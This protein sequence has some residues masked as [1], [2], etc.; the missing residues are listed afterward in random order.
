MSQPELKLISFTLCPYVQRARITLLKKG[1]QHEIEYIDLDSP[2]DWFFDI[3]PLEKVP[4]LL[5]DTKP[6][7]ESMV[8]C[9]YLDEISPGSLYPQDPFLRAQQRAWIQFGDTLLNNVYGTMTAEDEAGFKR[10]KAGVID[11]LDILEEQISE[12]DV[13]SNEFGMLDVSIAPTFRYMDAIRLHAGVDFYQ[14]APEVNAWAQRLAGLDVV[15]QA[16]PED[17]PQLIAAY[18]RRPQTV[19]KSLID[20]HTAN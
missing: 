5:V 14:A 1:L 9:E 17:Y 12:N 2:P 6:L 8:I 13:F 3:S 11:K 18:L 10:N 15:K 7:F 19:M 20:S 16:V 4:V